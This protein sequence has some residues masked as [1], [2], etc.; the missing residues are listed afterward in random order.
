MIKINLLAQRKRTGRGDR[1]QQE[2]LLGVLLIIAAGVLVWLFVQRPLR[3]QIDDIKETNAK[4]SAENQRLQGKLK[5]E[6]IIQAAVEQLEQREASI[7]ELQA[8]QA[9][10]AYMLRELSRLMTSNRLPT[11]TDEMRKQVEG[12]SLLRKFSTEWDPK[13]AW[14][15]SFE[16]KKGDF[17]LMGGAQSDGDVTQLAKR[18]EASVYFENVVSQGATEVEDRNSGITYFQFTITGKVIY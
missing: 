10:P 7:T 2:I 3:A 6:K 17:T 14:I 15:T 4:L 1:A 5:D 8:A 9:T 18:L 12:G 16:E 13:H 11:M